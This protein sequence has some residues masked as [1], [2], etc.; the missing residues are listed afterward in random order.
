[1]RRRLSAAVT[2]LVVALAGLVVA[3]NPAGAAPGDPPTVSHSVVCQAGT[4]TITVV[5]ENA[6]L[7]S[8]DYV[9]YTNGRNEG[10]SRVLTDPDTFTESGPAM[11]PIRMWVTH[12]GAT[13]YD[14]GEL[15]LAEDGTCGVPTPPLGQGITWDVSSACTATGVRVTL[16]VD[17]DQVLRRSWSIED[18]SWN[19]TQDYDGPA[20]HVYDV[21]LGHRFSATL[22][23]QWNRLLHSMPLFV[24]TDTITCMA[25]PVIDAAGVVEIECR[26]GQPWA[27][28]GATSVGNTLI[29][30]DVYWD[31]EETT[32]YG[33]DEAGPQ[34]FDD[35]LPGDTRW[36]DHGPVPFGAFVEVGVY[37][38]E[39]GET[40]WADATAP[41]SCPTEAPTSDDD[42]P[43]QPATPPPDPTTGRPGGSGAAPVEVAGTDASR[44]ALPRTGL[45]LGLAS[46][47]GVLLLAAG[48]A[49][50]TA[51]RRRRTA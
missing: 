5:V 12:E 49:L 14:T 37:L 16:D 17:T 38:T 1:M 27:S 44:S 24:A 43:G 9:S 3:T 46:G 30:P 40:V 42:P 25:T 18:E 32:Y 50:L 2:A 29:D 10:T 34:H 22:A 4:M 11:R 51:S 41:T 20:Q 26:D 35:I 21:P 23:D 33:Q 6:D 19:E 36:F 31:V 47:A 15:Y 39:R 13:V 7:A 28:V 48:Q 8:L 45:G